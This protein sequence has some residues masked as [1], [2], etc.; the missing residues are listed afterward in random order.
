MVGTSVIISTHN[1]R[2]AYLGR[3]LDAL[4]AQ[5]LAK[6]QWELIVV[7]NV[8]TE[9]LDSRVDLSWHPAARILRED[10]LGLTPAR[11][12]GIAESAGAILI[13]VDDDNVLATDYLEQSL[14]IGA[15]F[16][17]LGAWGGSIDL[18]F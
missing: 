14:K 3:V 1:P 5:T 7:D 18:E 17:F 15:D 11:L 16:P 6:E 2:P 9:P 4:R 12:R 10:E 8:C 13:F